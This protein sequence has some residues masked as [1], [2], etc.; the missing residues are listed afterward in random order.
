MGALTFCG[1]QTVKGVNRVEN[2]LS[3][4]TKKWW[5]GGKTFFGN[6]NDEALRER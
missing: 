6:R 1:V 2:T 3:A 4:K 5:E